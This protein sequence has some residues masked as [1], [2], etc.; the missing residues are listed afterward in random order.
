MTRVCEKH[1]FF[2]DKSM[3]IFFKSTSVRY[4]VK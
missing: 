3:D 2:S 1:K 4:D